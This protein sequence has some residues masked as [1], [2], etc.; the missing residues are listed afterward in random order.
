MAEARQAR[1]L[2][3]TSGRALDAVSR[4]SDCPAAVVLMDDDEASQLLGK[5]PPNE[6]AL[7][8]LARR[9]VVSGGV[10]TVILTLSEKGAMAVTEN[11]GWRVVPPVVQV[12]SKVGAGDSFMAGVVL[13]LR[14]GWPLSETV[15]FA[16]AAA[17]S[18]VTT[19]ATELCTK[20]G[21][22]VLRPAVK[23][24]PLCSPLDAAADD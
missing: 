11:G 5:G 2:I 15:T 9:L 17:A 1:A 7:H 4:S 24:T 8:A 18:A 10:E 22:E 23:C 16:V 19:P 3:D 20:K 12:A 6:A 14:R 13:G 21:T